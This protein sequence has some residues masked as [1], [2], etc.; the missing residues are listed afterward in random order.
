MA[1]TCYINENQGEQ[2]DPIWNSQ[3][4]AVVGTSAPSISSLSPSSAVPGSSGTLTLNGDNLLNLF[5]PTGQP[6]VT[7]STSSITLSSPPAPSPASTSVQVNY[8]IAAGA[9]PGSY[10]VTASN[11]W[12]TSNAAAFTVASGTKVQSQNKDIPKPA[13]ALS[14]M[15]TDAGCSGGELHNPTRIVWWGQIIGAYPAGD[16]ECAITNVM[17]GQQIQP[18]VPPF[19]LTGTAWAYPQTLTWTISDCSDSN[20]T[21]KTSTV[22]AVGNYS[23]T[24]GSNNVPTKS[25]LTTIGQVNMNQN[26]IRFYFTVPGKTEQVDVTGTFTD[27]STLSAW[28]RFNVEGPSVNLKATM[29]TNGS[30]VQVYSLSGQEWFGIWGVPGNTLNPQLGSTS[31]VMRRKSPP[32]PNRF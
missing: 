11:N 7:S 10:D 31:R 5:D 27:G 23:I 13:I 30:G 29:P 9:T 25:T 6:D 14:P 8:S 4:R 28:A 24:Y 21:T 18:Y 22:H 1:H 16:I 17:A 3:V 12:G 32:V 20:C 2:C 15:V 26:P 19:Y